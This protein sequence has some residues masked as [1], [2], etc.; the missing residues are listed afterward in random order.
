ML[1]E[2]KCEPACAAL[3]MDNNN[4]EIVAAQRERDATDVTHFSPSLVLRVA[5]IHN[6]RCVRCQISCAFLPCKYIP[7]SHKGQFL[8][9]HMHQSAAHVRLHVILTL[10]LEGKLK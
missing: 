10:L 5:I 9:A 4:S 8:T 1:Y 2:P 6:L 3:L 7:I